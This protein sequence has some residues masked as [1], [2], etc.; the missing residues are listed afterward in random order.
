MRIGFGWDLHKLEKGRKLILGGV[1]I[2]SEFGCLGHSDGDVVLHS[3]TDAILGSLALGDI[4]DHFKDTDPKWKNAESS[5][6]LKESLRLLKE[7]GFAISNIDATIILEKPKLYPYKEK[8]RENISK[9]L[10]LNI[11]QVSFKA[12]TREGIGEVGRSEAV[13]CYAVVLVVWK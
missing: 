5:I 6:F 11:D 8:I 12:K 10:E 7:K 3:I 1:E 4:G 13:E 2:P 9:I